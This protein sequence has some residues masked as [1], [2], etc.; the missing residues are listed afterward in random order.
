LQGGKRGAK[1]H[2]PSNG[3][4]LQERREKERGESDRPPS[5]SVKI[6]VGDGDTEGRERRGKKNGKKRQLGKCE[7]SSFLC[8]L[9][10]NFLPIFFGARALLHLALG[11]HPIG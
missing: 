4:S 6:R 8:L 9:I 3:F 1:F 5:G 11:L 7:S 2:A 10:L